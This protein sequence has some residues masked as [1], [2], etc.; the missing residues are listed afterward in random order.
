MKDYRCLVGRHDW[1]TELPEGTT[2]AR[3]GAASVSR[4]RC[5]K[6]ARAGSGHDPRLSGPLLKAGWGGD[7]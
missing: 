5:G 4:L 1:S 7:A 2:P 3:Q 6:A